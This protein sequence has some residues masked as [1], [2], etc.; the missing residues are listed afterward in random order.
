[1]IFR[2]GLLSTNLHTGS[3]AA[4]MLP[5]IGFWGFDNWQKL[6]ISAAEQTENTYSSR[7]S[8]QVSAVLL[9]GSKAYLPYSDK[10]KWLSAKIFLIFSLLSV[11]AVLRICVKFC[12]GSNT[13]PPVK[14]RRLCRYI[15]IFRTLL[16]RTLRPFV[17]RRPGGLLPDVRSDDMQTSAW[18]QSRRLDCVAPDVWTWHAQ[19]SGCDVSGRLHFLHACYR[20]FGGDKCCAVK[21]LAQAVSC[22]KTDVIAAW[23]GGGC[24]AVLISINF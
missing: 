7:F 22:C 9:S 23:Y 2:R 16:L 10:K 1:M 17:C 13:Q 21:G 6:R 14:C 11:R 20:R 8:I 3:I 18:C 24:Q 12:A 15:P 5:A 19:T 4:S